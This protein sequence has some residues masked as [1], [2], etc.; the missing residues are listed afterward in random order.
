MS[1]P[2][3]LGSPYRV[4][5]VFDALQLI[6]MLIAKNH[7]MSASQAADILNDSR[8]RTFR[9]LK[10][11]EESGYVIHSPADKTYRPSLKLLTLGQA[12]SKSYSI[13][14]L[15]REIMTEL[16]QAIRETV[17]L[18][19]REGLE[20]VCIATIESP[21]MVRITAQPG[22]RWPLGRGATGTALLVSAP[23]DVV[24]RYLANDPS[25]VSIYEKVKK[26]FE[27]DGVTFVDGRDGTIQDEGVL[28]ISSPIH[29]VSD[30]ANY[31]LAAA[32]PYTRSS[33]DLGQ[34][35]AALLE[36]TRAIERQLGV[37]AAAD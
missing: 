19:T 16:S 4:Q 8:N 5:S 1:V 11:L 9:L 24:N 26:Q 37:T 22:S 12:V 28:A 35:R 13:E 31:A 29:D 27:S 18:C 32:W 21:Q 23:D 10:T 2:D 25:K 20:S 34:I 14:S 3:T 15:S 36:A 7:P 30:N 17:Y 33:A 6:E